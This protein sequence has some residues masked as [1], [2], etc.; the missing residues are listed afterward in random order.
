MRRPKSRR[1]RRA[2]SG[3]T[4]SRLA[5]RV[6]CSRWTGASSTSLRS[7]QRLT[8]VFVQVPHHPRRSSCATFV[9]FFPHSSLADI[10]PTRREHSQPQH[11]DFEGGDGAR[12]DLPLGALCV[13]SLLALL[14][15]PVLT[16]DAFRSRNARHQLA[17]RYLPPPPL[18][19]DQA[20]VRVEVLQRDDQ[21]D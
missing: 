13:P 14:S 10:T 9:C 2:V 8:F 18:P 21:Q 3:K 6:R 7:E 15:L 11:S 16:V 20:L 4:T 17:R 1:R 19:P 5:R 12:V